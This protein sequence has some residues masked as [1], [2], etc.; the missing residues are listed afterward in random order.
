MPSQDKTAFS[1]RRIMSLLDGKKKMSKSDP[2]D[3]GRINLLDSQDTVRRKLKAAL[4]DSCNY[5]SFEPALRPHVAN[6]LSIYAALSRLPMS[7]ILA[8]YP[9]PITSKTS[10]FTSFKSD[11]ADLIIS[12]T[13]PIHERWHALRAQPHAVTDILE[14]GEQQANAIAGCHYQ[15]ISNL[16]GLASPMSRD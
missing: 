12:L 6:L 7:D 5:L 3:A 14:N 15:E 10:V 9:E 8:K 1:V 4:T 16:V 13:E 11:L 2:H